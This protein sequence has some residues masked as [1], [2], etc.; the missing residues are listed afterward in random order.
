MHAKDAARP[1][2]ADDARHDGY[3]ACG[4]SFLRKHV[5]DSL[6][7]ERHSKGHDQWLHLEYGDAEPIQQA[8]ES[9]DPKTQQNRGGDAVRRVCRHDV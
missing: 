7:D 9:A 2:F 6:N 5:Q 4:D 3:G 1:Q 8:D